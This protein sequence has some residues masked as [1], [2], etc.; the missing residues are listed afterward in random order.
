MI[1]LAINLTIWVTAV[2]EESTYHTN[3]LQRLL[4][5][6]FTE[7]ANGSLDE[8]QGTKMF[9]CGRIAVDFQCGLTVQFTWQFTVQCMEITACSFY[10]GFTTVH[11]L[12]CI[13]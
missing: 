9:R 11:P 4:Q 3:E 2:A 8:Q 1:L 6:N 5:T 7:D 10:C 12:Q 13:L